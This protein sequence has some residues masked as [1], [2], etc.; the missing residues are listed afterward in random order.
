[1]IWQPSVTVRVLHQSSQ[2]LTCEVQLPGS[3]MFI[4]TA[5]YA[6]NQRSER[7][8]LWVEL[9]NIHQSFQL[10]STPWM[11]GGDFNQIIHPAEH[12]VPAVN[13]LNIRMIELRD[14]LLQHDLY[15]LRYQGPTLT[16][17]NHQPDSPIAKKL[18]RLLISSPIL[19]LF[20][21]CTS[22]FLP[23]LFS[24]HCPCIVD[25]A[26]KLPSSGTKPFKFY[27]YLTKHPDFHQVVLQAWNEA[28]SS[29]VTNLTDLCVC[30]KMCRYN[31]FSHHPLRCSKGKESFFVWSKSD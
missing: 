31:H 22:T 27:N 25:L 6:S 16:W 29:L 8:G 24:D 9:L 7:S 17:S 5:I 15:D 20:P 21:N 1:M 30:C 28:G 19:N 2:S 18:D 11:L 26:F 13:S 12:S 14:T 23:P 10:H 4:Y 3:Q